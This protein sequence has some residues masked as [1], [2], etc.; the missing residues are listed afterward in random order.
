[1][2]KIFVNVELFSNKSWL[3]TSMKNCALA[4]AVS[5]TR[6]ST[7]AAFYDYDG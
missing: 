7:E 1:M 3:T 6:K 5:G 2:S 4:T